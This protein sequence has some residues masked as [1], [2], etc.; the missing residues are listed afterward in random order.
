M[1]HRKLLALG[2]TKGKLDLQDDKQFQELIAFLE[3]SHLRLYASSQRQFF[4]A[5]NFDKFLEEAAKYLSEI[6]CPFKLKEDPRE[7]VANWLIDYALDKAYDEEFVSRISPQGLF[8]HFTSKEGNSEA[9]EAEVLSSSLDVNSEKFKNAVQEL[10]KSIGLTHHPDHIV[11]LRAIEKYLSKA[12]DTA[13]AEK[14]NS[15]PSEQPKTFS[16]DRC[17]L[18][19]HSSGDPKVDSAIRALR[20]MHV[21]ELRTLQ[22]QINSLIVEVQ[23]IT[24]NPK[25]DLQLGRVGR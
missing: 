14:E 10:G 13:K 5:E 21:N 7:K 22:T 17:D 12:I 2:F 18:G 6:K 3:K 20:L 15:G 9:K 8:V 24:S 1:S 19:M 25:A 16:L 4:Q 11:S 23:K